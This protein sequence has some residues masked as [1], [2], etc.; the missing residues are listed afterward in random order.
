MQ[1][2]L[3]ILSWVL[4]GV[5]V[6]WSCSWGTVDILGFKTCHSCGKWVRG[7]SEYRVIKDKYVWCSECYE[8][9]TIVEDMR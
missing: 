9:K 2:L 4:V 8:L 5:I 1:K 3:T 6:I 7:K